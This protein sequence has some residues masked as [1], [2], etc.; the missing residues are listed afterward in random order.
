MLQIEF[1]GSRSLCHPCWQRI[2]Y[3][4]RRTQRQDQPAPP[5]PPS[6]Q[7]ISPTGLARTAN[8]SRRC[9]FEN[10]NNLRLRQVPNTLKAYLLSY[11]NLYI[12]PLSRICQNHLSNTTWEDFATR[13]SRRLNDFNAEYMQDI[14]QIYT[15]A[16]EQKSSLNFENLNEIDEN[17]LHF[18]TGVN[19]AQFNSILNEV[20]SLRDMSKTPNT[21]LAAYLCK[22][23]TG[24]PGVRL[25]TVFGM[26][27]QN[28]ERKIHLARECLDRDFVSIHLG[29]DHIT[30]EEVMRRNRRIPNHIFGSDPMTKAIIICDGT[31]LYLQ[32]SANFLF[33]RDSYSLHKY[34]NLIKPFLIVCADG[35][36]IEVSGPYAATKSDATIMQNILNNHNGPSEDAPILWFLNAGDALILDRGFRD[37]I[38]NL[39]ECGF[40]PHMP[41]SKRRHET[42]LN[43]EDANKSRLITMVR[44]VV[45]TINGR[46]KRDFKI[47]RNTYFNKS[48]PFA[49]TDFRIAAALINAFQEPYADSQYSDEFIN[50]VNTNMHKPNLLA[51][52]V[53]QH[54]MNRQRVAFER[55]EANPPNLQD[56]PRLTYH[57]LILFAVGTYHLKI[58][59]SYC[60]EH[61]RED[62]TYVIEV[63]RHPHYINIGGLGDKTLLRG[64]IQSRHVRSRTYYTYILYTPGHNSKDAIVEHV[65][66]CIH[67][68]RTLGSC[69]HIISMLYYLAFARHEGLQQPAAF[70]DSVLLDLENNNM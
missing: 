34:K 43:T 14:I 66:S 18:W 41:P 40:E 64:R 23:R 1:N 38:P 44:W 54:N 5:T 29:F 27:R 26:S 69:A 3:A 7:S 19:H 21:D 9:I 56:F 57:E 2:D 70:F 12:C 52:Y 6:R 15:K 53:E 8:S 36:I 13:I 10:C 58:A 28:L 50:I 67:G 55:L 20:S 37:V 63:Y 39:E 24:E 22:I 30:Q 60:W 33:Q 42:Q 59:R 47:F 49:M 31:Y 4:L 65:C 35:Y 16:L 25:A 61:V 32:K 46:F 11:Y 45:E 62:G 17:T 51:D 48:A 68:R